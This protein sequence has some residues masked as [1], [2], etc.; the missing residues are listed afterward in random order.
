MEVQDANAEQ[1]L[2]LPPSFDRS[3]VLVPR[4]V[5][6]GVPGGPRRLHQRCFQVVACGEARVVNN[7]VDSAIADFNDATARDATESGGDEATLL[8]DMWTDDAA[9]VLFSAGDVPTS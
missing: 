1:V 4:V 6:S 3:C 9:A 5:D 7:E 2:K 8:K